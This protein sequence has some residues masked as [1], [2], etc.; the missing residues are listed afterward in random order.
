MEVSSPKIQKLI[1]FQKN[2][3]FDISR[4]NFKAPSLK[5]FPIFFV[6][7]F[8]KMNLSFHACFF[9]TMNLYI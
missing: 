7:F 8:K 2:N 9:E 6:F 1:F 3:F 5:K 4:R